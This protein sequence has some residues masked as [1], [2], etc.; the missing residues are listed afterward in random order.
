M[1]GFEVADEQTGVV[2]KKSTSVPEK[3]RGHS[4]CKACV[5]DGNLALYVCM[6][7]SY[8][9]VQVRKEVNIS[10]WN[11]ANVCRP[12]PLHNSIPE[13]SA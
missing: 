13:N 1:C 9:K 5:P 3:I 2:I 12:P 7:K 8:F 6:E 4:Q 11:S 10:E